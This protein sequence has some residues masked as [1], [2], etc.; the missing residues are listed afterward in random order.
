MMTTPCAWNL[1]RKINERPQWRA[2]EEPSFLTLCEIDCTLITAIVIIYLL[3]RSV[4]NIA[5][6][7]D[8]L[9]INKIKNDP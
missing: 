9:P 1:Q 2:V 4:V 3:S 5:I 7:A 8:Q 6:F